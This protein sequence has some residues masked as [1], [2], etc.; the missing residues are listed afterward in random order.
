M[1]KIY[2]IFSIFILLACSSTKQ[3]QSDI[4]D[5]VI[6]DKISEAEKTINIE[7]YKKELEKAGFFR[8]KDTDTLKVSI[9]ISSENWKKY[10]INKVTYLERQILY[11]KKTLKVVRSFLKYDKGRFK[12]GNEYFYNDKGE[13]IKTIDHNQYNKYPICYKD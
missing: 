7:P 8:I 10:S 6:D 3:I 5:C 13:V 2:L 9:A 4:S 11:D 12:I 1:K